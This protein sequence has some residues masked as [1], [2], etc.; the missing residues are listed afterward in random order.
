MMASLPAKQ[1]PAP[2]ES[3]A[4]RF[5]RLAALWHQDTDFLSSM[6]ESSDHPAYQEIIGL[7]PAVV[8]LLLRDLELNHTHWFDA[9]QAITG[10]DPV[11]A[12]TGGNIAKMAE[13]WIH[14]AKDQGYRW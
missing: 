10:A 8:P 14:W 4:E 12:S 7:G 5:R 3:L 6:E 1:P 2:P 11:P 13:A 9:L